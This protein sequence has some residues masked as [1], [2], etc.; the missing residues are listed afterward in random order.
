MRHLHCIQGR[1]DTT[2]KGIR[3]VQDTYK[4]HKVGMRQP[5][6]GTRWVQGTYKAYDAGARHLQE[7]QGRYKTPTR[8]T[9]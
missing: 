3:Q 7:V 6:R 9:K 4:V 8:H 1:Y 5:T 2:Y